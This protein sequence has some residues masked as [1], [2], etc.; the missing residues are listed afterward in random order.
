[1]N[2]LQ[3]CKNMAI[4]ISP[5][6][7]PRGFIRIIQF[8]MAIL[9]FAT[10]VDY[11]GKHQVEIVCDRVKI[12]DDPGLHTVELV[13][14]EL[15]YPFNSEQI[16]FFKTNATN[17][18]RGSPSFLPFVSPL[19]KKSTAEFYVTT[20]VLSFLFSITAAVVY[21]V[22]TET[23]ENS[24]IFPFVDLVATAVLAFFWF[25]SWCTWVAQEGK[26]KSYVHGMPDSICT[27]LRV[28]AP[29][30]VSFK[31]VGSSPSF[32]KLT[33]S[34]IF[35]F[36]NIILWAGS[37]WFVFKE[38]HFHKKHD[39]RAEYTTSEASPYQQAPYQQAP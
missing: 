13:T 35:G 15:S 38:T 31:C 37:C 14:Y 27:F 17:C 28:Q 2:N 26:V 33:S 9:A 1:M 23:Y 24:A 19:N 32:A 4:D 34:L 8:F 10:T 21:V 11:R 5:L 6:K 22:L 18:V 25:I 30:T 36:G 29:E 16:F 3:D 20:G 39:M 7:E 12:N